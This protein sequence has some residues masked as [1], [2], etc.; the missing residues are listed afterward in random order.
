[1]SQHEKPEVGVAMGCALLIG[2]SAWALLVLF[3]IVGLIKW[4]F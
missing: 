3:A 2:A 4:A 1:V